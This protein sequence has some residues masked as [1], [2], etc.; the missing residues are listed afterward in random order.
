MPCC[1]FCLVGRMT[2][3]KILEEVQE[4]IYVTWLLFLSV[5]TRAGHACLLLVMDL[6]LPLPSFLPFAL[7]QV[8]LVAVMKPR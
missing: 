6:F 4:R 8:L 2:R 1:P 7:I 3:C 5:D